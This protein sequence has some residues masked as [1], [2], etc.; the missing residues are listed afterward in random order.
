[1]QTQQHLNRHGHAG[2]GEKDLVEYNLFQAIAYIL[3]L[4]TKYYRVFK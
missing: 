2:R 4:T 1:M 3:L